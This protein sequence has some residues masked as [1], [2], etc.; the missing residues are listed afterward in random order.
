M[1]SVA[2]QRPLDSPRRCNRRGSVNQAVEDEEKAW[3]SPGWQSRP[4]AGTTCGVR[5]ATLDV[6]EGGAPDL[7]CAVVPHGGGTH[8]E[9]PV[10]V[11]V[12]DSSRRRRRRSAPKSLNPDTMPVCTSPDTLEWNALATQRSYKVASPARARNCARTELKV[13]HLSAHVSPSFFRVLCGAAHKFPS[14]TTHC[15]GTWSSDLPVHTVLGRRKETRAEKGEQGRKVT[16]L[17]PFPNCEHNGARTTVQTRP[18]PRSRR[19]NPSGAHKPEPENRMPPAR[20]RQRDSPDRRTV[21]TGLSEFTG[22][23]PLVIS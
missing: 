7:G 4:G 21:S 22:K 23:P 6:G 1:P 17:R 5:R 9:G 19:P 10:T 15:R 14:F 13:T 3:K 20:K 8:L 18:K 11:V 12:E 2:A 16:S